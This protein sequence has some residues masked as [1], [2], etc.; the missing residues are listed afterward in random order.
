MK[1]VLLGS[2][3]RAAFFIRIARA[4]PSLLTIQAVFTHSGERAKQIGLPAFTNLD[5]ALAVEHDLVIVASGGRDFLSTMLKLKERGERVLVETTFL[6]LSDEENLALADMK[7][8][9]AE[10]Y[11]YTPL[12]ASIM[13]ALPLIGRPTQLYLSG[14]HNHHAAS[15]A[16]AVL[17]LGISMPDSIQSFNW[18]DGILKTAS[19]DGMIVNGEKEEYERKIRLLTFGDRLFINDFSS[20]QYHSH[21]YGKRVEIRGERGVVDEKG[22]RFVNAEGYPATLPFVFHRDYVM[23]NAGMTLSHVT[24]GSETVFVNPFY[25]AQFNDDEIAI[26]TILNNLDEGKDCPTIASGIQDAR[27]GRLL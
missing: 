10:Q 26:A 6:S 14:L 11:L 13:K 19:R 17:S 25:P 20:N 4:L 7:G 21:L 9:V 5:K 27:L 18:K 24:L 12:Y 2:G 23:G 8:A 15:V 1:A 3:W 22:V 16:R